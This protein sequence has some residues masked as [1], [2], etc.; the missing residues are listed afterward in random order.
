MKW[1]SHSIIFTN[2]STALFTLEFYR[3]SDSIQVIANKIHVSERKIVGAVVD[4]WRST[5]QGNKVPPH[6]GSIW[7]MAKPFFLFLIGKQ[8]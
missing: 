1:I 5:K 6:E 2:L 8:L 3:G 7:Q 4:R